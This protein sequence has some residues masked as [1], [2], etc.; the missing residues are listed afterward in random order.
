RSR[1]V[2]N[3]IKSSTPL[4]DAPYAIQDERFK[5]PSGLQLITATPYPDRDGK[6][7]PGRSLQIFFRVVNG[8]TPAH[9]NERIGNVSLSLFPVPVRD[10]LNVRLSGGES[11][12]F[13]FTLRNNTGQAVYSGEYL[14]ADDKVTINMEGM[15]SGL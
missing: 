6:G 5:S 9:F 8:E 14:S 1:A 4:N 12:T 13:Q 15:P 11:E 10:Q 7:E 2:R 3:N